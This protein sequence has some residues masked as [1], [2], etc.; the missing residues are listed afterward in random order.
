MKELYDI[1]DYFE[2]N[3]YN[4][5]YTKYLSLRTNYDNYTALYYFDNFK[6][7]VAIN[8]NINDCKLYVWNNIDKIFKTKL[9]E[10]EFYKLTESY[11]DICNRY[12]ENFIIREKEKIN[13]LD[14]YLKLNLKYKK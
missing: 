8:L 9:N 13:D 12:N 4:Y 2:L 6:V 11:I 5:D 7:C 3:P 1:N 14:L 10:E